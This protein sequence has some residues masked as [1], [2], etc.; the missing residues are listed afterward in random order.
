[1]T[2]APPPRRSLPPSPPPTAP[3]RTPAHRRLASA[4]TERLPLKAAAVF[5]AIVLWFVVNAK[6]PQV[7][8]V[9][10]RFS[11]VLD[12]SLV[13]QNP[14]TNLQAIVAGAPKELIKL[15]STPPIIRRPISAD[16]PDTVV[17]DLRPDD[18][19]LPEGVNAVVTDVSP[20]SLTLHFES[21]WTRKVPVQVSVDVAPMN[22]PGPVTTQFEPETVQVTGPRHLVLKIS[23][24][25]TVRQTITYP[26]SL[27]HLVDIDTTGFGPV[28]VHPS[29]VKVSLSVLPHAS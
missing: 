18:V 23:S 10:V 14:P 27:T 13:L 20:R 8:L 9:P 17:V 29:Q 22:A 28:H 24:V 4:F 26:D 3:A 2:L 11:P 19:M 12:T 1:M 21:T 6:E 7:E 16:T 5:L 15:S 25:H